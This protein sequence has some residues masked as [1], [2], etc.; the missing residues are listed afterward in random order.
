I[1][2]GKTNSHH[3]AKAERLHAITE[4]SGTSLNKS[5]SALESVW[6]VKDHLFQV[7]DAEANDGMGDWLNEYQIRYTY[8]EGGLQVERDIDSWAEVSGDLIYVF[9]TTWTNNEQCLHG[10]VTV[11]SCNPLGDGGSGAWII[12]RRVTRTYNER[13]KVLVSSTEFADDG[14]FFIWS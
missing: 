2:D 10:E 9:L 5:A 4:R 6:R 11:S 14:D 3:S 7:W 12:A 8:T 1:S 13:R